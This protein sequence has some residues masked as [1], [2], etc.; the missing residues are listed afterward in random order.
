MMRVQAV[1]CIKLY[2]IVDNILCLGLLAGPS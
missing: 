2:K 1:P